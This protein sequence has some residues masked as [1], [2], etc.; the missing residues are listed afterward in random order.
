[1]GST[2][3]RGSS[4]HTLVCSAFINSTTGLISRRTFRR[5]TPWYFQGMRIQIFPTDK[6][7]IEPWI[8]NGWQSYGKFNRAPGVGGQVLW[9]PNGQV[10]IVANNYWG[11]DTLGNPGRKRIHTDDSIQVKYLDRP[12]SEL[13]KAAFTVTVGAGCEYGGGGRCNGGS[14]GKT[15]PYVLCIM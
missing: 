11:T 1:M 12:Q 8:I 6:L 9:R 14:S 13:S 15:T 4:C 3:M 10:S 5:N 7:K 2:S